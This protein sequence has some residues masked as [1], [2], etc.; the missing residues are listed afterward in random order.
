MQSRT[1]MPKR[2]LRTMNCTHVDM[3]RIYGRDQHCFVCGRSPSIGFLY[4]CR[5]DH[6][7]ESLYD[8]LSPKEDRIEVVRSTLRVELEVIGLSKSVILTAEQGDYTA[9]QLELLKSQKREL[10]QIIADTLQASQINDAVAKLAATPSNH[11][12]ALSSKP[13]MDTKIPPI[14]AFKACHTC[15]PYYRDRVYISFQAVL[16]ADFAPMKPNDTQLL[17]TKSAQIMRNIGNTVRPYSPTHPALPTSSTGSP[18][19]AS[20]TSE[21][22]E[23]TFKTTQTD[24]DQ[25]RAQR[26]PRRRFYKIGHRSSGEIARDLSRLPP[27]LTPH[28]LKTA[29]QGIFR[30][31]RESS[32][33]GSNITLPLPRTG[34]VRDLHGTESVGEFDLGA[35]RRVRRQKERNEIRNGTYVGGYEDVVIPPVTGAALLGM[36]DTGTSDSSDLSVYSCV[37]ESSEADG[38]GDGTEG[39]GEIHALD[40]P[41]KKN[42]PM[43]HVD[44][45]NDD[46]EDEDT[47]MGDGLQSIMAQR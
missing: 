3:D 43:T 4:E 12:G 27:F 22:S 23:L 41:G 16:A 24:L 2:R 30:P 46:D 11:D 36:E 20:T 1:T 15:R 44:E 35:L 33:E 25:I 28:G 26:R 13:T 39:A 7:G 34:T 8:I 10:K 45:V 40:V 17:P 19:T 38:S 5:Q 47:E 32:S 18:Q 37:S 14:C 42:A 6:D 29:I 31:S 9:A 21:S